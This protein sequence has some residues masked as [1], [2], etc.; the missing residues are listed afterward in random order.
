MH[1]ANPDS[2]VR[3][4]IFDK[5]EALTPV[6]RVLPRS[7]PNPKTLARRHLQYLLL[8]LATVFSLVGWQLIINI[9][10]YPPYLLPSPSRVWDKA[11]VVFQDDSLWYHTSYTMFEAFWGFCIAFVFAMVAGHYLA[12]SPLLED[13]ISPYIV[14]AQ[15]TPMLA[16]APLLI[17][18]F[19]VGPISK[20]IIAFVLV[21]LPMLI[22][23]I[24]GFRS[25]SAE[26]RQLMRSYSATRR[27]TFYLLE[28]PAAMP[29]L[30][31]GI[32]VGLVHA[33][34]GALVGEYISASRGL[35]YWI[36]VGKARYDTALVFTA[37]GTMVVIN[38]TLYGFLTVVERIVLSWR[39]E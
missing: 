1:V 4:Y 12:H 10:N 38:V 2:N 14:I 27:Q 17:V 39:K 23:A 26:H 25:V 34:S 5:L 15:A 37:L 6:L 31:G 32:K 33:M 9:R 30:L 13:L 29:L 35:G 22:S 16:I 7:A 20:I 28:I 18:W 19:G 36:I 24:V 8:P 21:V 3:G 11:V